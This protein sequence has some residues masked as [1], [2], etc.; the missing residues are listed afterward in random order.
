MPLLIAGLMLLATSISAQARGLAVSNSE[1][2]SALSD[3]LNRRVGE[4]RLERAEALIGERNHASM[5]QLKRFY[6][7]AWIVQE[8]V[9]WQNAAEPNGEEVPWTELRLATTDVTARD[10]ERLAALFR[11]SEDP[12]LRSMVIEALGRS[13][14]SRA[15]VLLVNLYQTT[16]DDTELGQILGRIRPG[17]AQDPLSEFLMVE[18]LNRQ[19]PIHLRK[20]AAVILVLELGVRKGRGLASAEKD[21]LFPKLFEVIW[22]EQP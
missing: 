18:A 21:P 3:I 11:D 8:Q 5:H 2:E 15:Q 9:P 13:T 7:D 4:D 6:A 14:D 22:G 16:Q 17:S 12:R 1:G 19:R 20:Q 10:L